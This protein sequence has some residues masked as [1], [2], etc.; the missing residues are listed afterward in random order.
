MVRLV[1]AFL[2]LTFTSAPAWAQTPQ[3]APVTTGSITGTVTMETGQPVHG[4]LVIIIGS[5]RTATT[6]NDG[7]FTVPA[8]AP[9]TYEVIAQREHLTTGRQAVTVTAGQP[10]TVHFKLSLEALHEEVVVTASA[11][12]QTTTFESFNSITSLDTVEIAKNMGTSLADVLEGHAGIAKRSFGPGSARPIIRG[13]DGDRVLIMQDGV[14]TGDLSSQSADHGTSIDAASLQRIEVVKGPATLL[15]GSNAL[16]G[17]VNAITP[18]EAFRQSPFSGLLGSVTLDGGTANAQAGGNGSV[19]WG[20]GSW[21]LWGN[22]GAR[23]SGD[24]DTPIGKIENSKTRLGNAGGGVGWAGPRGFFSLGAKYEDSRFGVPFAGEFHHHDEEEEEEG[25]H[26]EEEAFVDLASDRLDLRLDAGLQ[27][28][29]GRFIDTARVIV[30]F[31]DYQH[32]EIEIDGPVEEIGTTFNNNVF[33]VRGE[34]LQ[35]QVGRLSGRMGVE[36]FFRDYEAVGEEA[37]APATRQTS[38]AG[39]IYEEAGFGRLRLQFG[40]RVERNA[41]DVDAR[42]GVDEDHD[43]CI[44][45]VGG[46]P[47]AVRNRDFTGVSGSAGVHVDLN[48]NA[49]IVANVSR[50]SRAPALE[51]LY[52]FGPHIGNL[53]FEVGNPKLGTENTLGFDLSLRGRGAKA[54]GEINFY[55]YEIGDFVFLDVQDVEID[56]LRLAAFQQA[57][58]RF[59]GMDASAHVEVAPWLHVNADLGLVRARLTD[60]SEHLPRIPPLQAR[61]ELEI[62]WR[63]LTVSPEVVFTS[64]QRRVFRDETPT[65]GSTVFNVSAMYVLGQQHLTHIFTLQGYN[66]TNEE[67]RLHTS[68]IKDL[69]PEMGRGV[70]ATYSVKFF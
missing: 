34:L 47:P 9:G 38:L 61:V 70:K 50:A 60:T 17:V 62:P 15:Y 46:C 55:T 45:I 53:A 65:G 40:A 14:R 31:L 19:Q 20:N 37:L 44:A 41:Y 13:F 67:Y 5:P 6:D 4:A 28:M 3:Q 26:D 27:N 48:G 11:T 30:S 16:G 56:G 18:Q 64:D 52:N 23:R 1:Y 22:G 68:F 7:A 29:Q 12:G 10:A 57:D 32:R 49:A 43:V 54:N 69:A 8:V 25:V 36:T 39:F 24:Y 59:S 66:L 35:K 51:E 58:S 33:S 63:Q 42:P 2:I 21:M